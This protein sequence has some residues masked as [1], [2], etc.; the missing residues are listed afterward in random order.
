[1]TDHPPQS[2]PQESTRSI[3]ASFL[4]F[5]GPLVGGGGLLAI[6]RTGERN[7]LFA[8]LMPIGIVMWFAGL[9]LRRPGG[10]GPDHGKH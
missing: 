3:T 1:M 8:L 4:L 5:T 9:W 6:L 10:E 2:R 7:A